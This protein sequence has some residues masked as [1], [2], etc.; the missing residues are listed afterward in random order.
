[1]LILCNLHKWPGGKVESPAPGLTSSKEPILMPEAAS[2]YRAVALT[3]TM[4]DGDAR[5]FDLELGSRLGFAMPIDIRKIVRRHEDNLLKFGVLATVAKTPGP[6]GGAPSKAYYLNK[7][8]AIFITAKSETAQATE[9]TIEIIERFDAYERGLQTSPPRCIAAELI[10]SKIADLPETKPLASLGAKAQAYEALAG[11]DGLHS[12]RSAAQQCSWPEHAFIGQLINLGWIYRSQSGGRLCAYA[13]KIKAGFMETKNVSL[14]RGKTA[15]AVG[16]PMITQRGLARL[17]AI[18]GAPIKDRVEPG[19]SAPP[20]DAVVQITLAGVSPRFR[21][22]ATFG[23][24]DG[25]L[26]EACARFSAAQ[27]ESLAIEA[28]PAAAFDSDEERAVNTRLNM[29]GDHSKDA[30]AII[31]SIPAVT[32]DGIWAKADALVR[33][34]P[35]GPKTEKLEADDSEV[36]LALSLA[37]DV[38]RGGE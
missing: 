10:G 30:I 16:Q 14:P 24:L 26:L 32:H 20:A 19:S 37:A 7:K 21:A 25:K 13:E 3:P 34:F 11:L 33:A 18:I 22:P 31:A 12:L 5:V 8:Q 36:R 29:L 1:M 35:L 9:I 6:K 17:K 38:L 28:M 15:A 4:V 23:G 2:D 27:V